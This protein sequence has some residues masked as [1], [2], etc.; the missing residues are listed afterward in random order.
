MFTVPQSQVNYNVRLSLF[1]FRLS[2]RSLSEKSCLALS[3][4]L[5]CPTTCLREVDLSN[6]D[7][8][9]SK[10]ELLL[11]GLKTSLCPLEV[12]R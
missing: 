10:L 12:L 6:N 11:T 7:L 1:F 5:S 4:V 8:K 3:P 2:V 9:D